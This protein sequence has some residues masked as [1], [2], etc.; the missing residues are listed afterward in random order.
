MKSTSRFTYLNSVL[1]T[2]FAFAMALPLAS[3]AAPGTRTAVAA[4]KNPAA[5]AAMP[6]SRQKAVPVMVEMSGA[7]A[8]VAYAEALKTAQARF[9]AQ[10]SRALARPKLRS[11]KR[12][13][14]QTS[15]EI[16]SRAA[17]QVA[18]NVH[19]LDQAQK[20]ILSS[21]T[22]KTIAGKGSFP[23]ATRIQRHRDAG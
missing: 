12:V 19:Q 4:N 11:S 3:Q 20:A 21:L 1:T 22:G 15:V 2:L 18:N 23:R 17:K 9:E 16:D 5:D 10:R 13:L 8:A 7:P 14:A 6:P